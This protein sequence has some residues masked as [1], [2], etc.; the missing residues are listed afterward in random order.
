MNEVQ[1]NFK[2]LLEYFI[3]TTKEA[4]ENLE[5]LDKWNESYCSNEQISF[6]KLNRLSSQ[7]YSAIL[8]H[9]KFPER[10]SLT[11]EDI[12]K[13][14]LALDDF[15]KILEST[16]VNVNIQYKR[17]SIFDDTGSGTGPE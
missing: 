11:N 2:I 6:P 13:A 9:N 15:K 7:V 12:Q 8:T 3:K 5:I 4:K 1:E 16:G 14:Q 10:L 17:D